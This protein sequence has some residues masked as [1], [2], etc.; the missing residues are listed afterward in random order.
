MAC[1][2]QIALNSIY[3]V[4]LT[5]FNTVISIATEGF[6]LSYAM[7]LLS[8]IIGQ[9]NGN[10]KTLTGPYSLGRYGILMNVVGLAFLIFT[11]IT[12]NF[13]TLSPVDRENM[14]YTSA[15]IGIIAIISIVTWITTGRE[16]FTGPRI[17]GVSTPTSTCV[18]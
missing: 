13:Q 10:K 6:Y 12:F 4:T 17:D 2:V 11:S 7:P 9:L 15:A 5:G 14:N 8:R 16:A 1:A 18:K 3:F